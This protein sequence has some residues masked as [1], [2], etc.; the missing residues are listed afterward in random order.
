[1]GLKEVDPV[2]PDPIASLNGCFALITSD[3]L[4]I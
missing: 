4:T 2:E 3:H 1:M